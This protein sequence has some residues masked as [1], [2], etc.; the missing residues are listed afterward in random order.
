MLYYLDHTYAQQTEEVTLNGTSIVATTATDIFRINHMEASAVGTGG[1]A[2]GTI[3]LS[4]HGG[5]TK[6]YAQIGVGQTRTRQMI[7]TVALGQTL[8]LTNVMISGV[9]G[10]A[11]HWCKFTLRATY[12]V[13]TGTIRNFF[14]PIFET[15]V[16]DQTV[17]RLFE[18]PVKIPATT[19]IRMIALSDGASAHEIVSCALRGYL[20]S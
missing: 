16:V 5:T 6:T 11:G 8:Y 4:E 17:D 18:I 2:A 20:I 7:Y 13:L 15:Q 12:D 10:A 9:N 19:D 3:T 1:A 14:I